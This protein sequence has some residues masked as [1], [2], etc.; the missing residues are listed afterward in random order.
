MTSHGERILF[1]ILHPFAFILC[2]AACLL[3]TAPPLGRADEPKAEPK[4]SVL[5]S[6]PLGLASGTTTKLIVRGLLLEEAS[7]CRVEGSPLV[8]KILSKGKA[9]LPANTDPKILGDTQV[10]IEA[11]APD[12][13]PPGDVRFTVVTPKGESA[14]QR[15]CAWWPKT[16]SCPSAS[17]TAAFATPS[18]SSRAR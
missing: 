6:T 18:R 7:E 13:L 5:M 1:F 12:D 10:E 16:S 2:L 17:P 4:P 15:A 9:P 11:T 14:A 8:L 3:A